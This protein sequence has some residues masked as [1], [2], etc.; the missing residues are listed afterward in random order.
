[1]SGQIV[2]MG[3]TSGPVKHAQMGSEDPHQRERKFSIWQALRFLIGGFKLNK[4]KV[5]WRYFDYIFSVIL[6]WHCMWK[7]NI[8]ICCTIN[9]AL[10]ILSPKT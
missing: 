10:V 2:S 7:Y 1:M 6:D 9:M 8:F 3:E 5:R 4:A